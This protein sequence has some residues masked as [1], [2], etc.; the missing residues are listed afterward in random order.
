MA[1]EYTGKV[2]I[3]DVEDDHQYA[4]LIDTA[5]RVVADHMR[6][7]CVAIADGVLPDYKDRGYVIRRIL[8]RAIRYAKEK[9]FAQCGSLRMLVKPVCEL[10]AS[11]FEEFDVD[12]NPKLIETIEM[13]I[14][15]E[16]I[17]FYKNLDRGSA[18][19]NKHLKLLRENGKTI[20]SGSL[21]WQLNQS[22][23]FP[24][25]LITLA[26]EEKGFTVDI[27]GY[28]KDR[29][30]AL[31]NSKRKLKNQIPDD[32]VIDSLEILPFKI[33]VDE[34]LSLTDDSYKYDYQWI[35]SDDSYEFY[36][37]T[38]TILK[39]YVENDEGVEEVYEV[40][41]SADK[42]AI[43]VD[44]TCMYSESGGQLSD[45]GLI[46][47]HNDVRF[48]V[49]N[50]QK[51][52]GIVAH[53]GR[54]L[55]LGSLKVNDTVQVCIHNM[56]RISLMRNHS[57]THILNWVLSQLLDRTEQRGSVVA[58]DKLRFDFLC[59]E[60][61]GAREVEY[62]ESTINEICGQ[63]YTRHIETMN[64]QNAKNDPQI[65]FMLSETYPDVVRVVRFKFENNENHSAELCGGTH[66]EN[67]SSIGKIIIT[68]LETIA[69][70]VKRIVAVT[71]PNEA[72]AIERMDAMFEEEIN[73]TELAYEQLWKEDK[74]EEIIDVI[75]Q[76]VLF[77]A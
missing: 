68:N 39:I 9:L 50:V 12:K 29:V 11:S 37:V 26:C 40:D 60:S 62:I 63:G 23:G 47:D 7:V 28:E 15:S 33:L 18:L 16:E 72:S 42:V 71:G 4:D 44:K 5:Y 64:L 31:T 20:L 73:V 27:E 32:Q 8:R 19:L 77:G 48:N 49:V 17:Q 3:E 74:V 41:N 75:N 1:L 13:I 25:D 76:W 34:N 58:E 55:S 69:R 38:A 65:R 24:L 10:L 30:E 54:I 51:F 53:Y 66:L 61:F 67:T 45:T 57:A 56:R 36:D 46:T 14:G 22:N 35:S 43:V 59:T 70:N 21:A 2:G 52:N 6:T